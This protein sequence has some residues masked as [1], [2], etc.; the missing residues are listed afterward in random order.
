MTDQTLLKL[1]ELLLNEF[2]EPEL[3][4]LCKDIGLDYEMLAGTG[5]FGKTRAIVEAART[6]DKLRLLQSRVRELRPEA[7]A[8]IGVS[9]TTTGPEDAAVEEAAPSQ[10]RE[11]SGSLVPRAVLPLLALLALVVIAALVLPR[12]IGGGQAASPTSAPS[13]TSAPAEGET[14]AQPPAALPG[15]AAENIE[16]A[17]ATPASTEGDSAIPVVVT[18]APPAADAPTSE[19]TPVEVT[20]PQ[21]SA[22]A[23]APANTSDPNEMHPAAQNVRGMNNQ[24][25]LFYTGKVTAKELEDYW[26]GEA[27]RLVTGFGNTRLPRAMRILPTQR[28]SLEISFE[29]LRPPTLVSETADS[30]VVTSREFW[31]YANTINDAQICEVRDYVYNLVRDGDRYRVRNFQSRLLENRC[32]S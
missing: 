29:Y 17:D 15:E 21:A 4:A 6:Q 18:V 16:P 10:R 13:V 12:V 28:E 5:T 9:S 27:L 23:L 31:R 24:L 14:A 19:P 22:T 11:D 2:S 32:P 8:A 7:Y 30:A 3:V 20:A 25:S 26:T 1:R